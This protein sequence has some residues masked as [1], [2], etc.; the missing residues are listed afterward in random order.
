MVENFTILGG[1]F[2]C[3]GMKCFC[4]FVDVKELEGE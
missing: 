3:E 4:L 1:L 2:E